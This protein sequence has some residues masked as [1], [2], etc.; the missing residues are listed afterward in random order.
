MAA[1]VHVVKYAAPA[2][3]KQ[4]ARGLLATVSMGFPGHIPCARGEQ[5]PTRGKVLRN[6]GWSRGEEYKLAARENITSTPA[7]TMTHEHG[8]QDGQRLS[9]SSDWFVRA[10]RSCIRRER[11]RFSVTEDEEARTPMLMTH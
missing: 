11:Q 7:L 10:Q 2:Q 9:P 5:G 6:T 3:L 4:H 8:G 1:M